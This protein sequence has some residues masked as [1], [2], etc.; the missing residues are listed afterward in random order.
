LL[1]ISAIFTIYTGWDYFRHGIHHVLEE[2]GG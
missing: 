1:W 2:D